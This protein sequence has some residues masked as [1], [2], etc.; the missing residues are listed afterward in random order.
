MIKPADLKKP[1]HPLK[2]IW[3]QYF[4]CDGFSTILEHDNDDV[5]DNFL[6]MVRQETGEDVDMRMVVAVP[7]WDIFNNPKERPRSKKKPVVFEEAMIEEDAENVNEEQGEYNEND[8]TNEMV[9]NPENTRAVGET[10]GTSE[11]QEVR[12]AE[13]VDGV[14]KEKRSKKPNE[15]PPHFEEEKTMPAK[16]TKTVA[17]R[18][19]RKA[20]KTGKVFEPNTDSISKAQDQPPPSTTID[21]T[22]PL[23][24]IKPTLTVQLSSSSSSP[25]SSSSS[26]SS[27]SS[28]EETESDSSHEPINTLLKRAPKPKPKPTSTLPLS[29]SLSLKATLFLITLHLTSQEMHLPHSI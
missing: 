1:D 29:N 22:I 10:D 20:T 17:P 3:E 14:E 8:S 15:K 24:M 5:I 7:D 6:E 21:Y 23:R 16:R 26:E 19:T 28:S 12:A 25:S 27:S 4:W 2:K 9:D 11:R 13:K 18:R